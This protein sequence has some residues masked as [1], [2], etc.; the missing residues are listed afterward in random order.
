VFQPPRF[1]RNRSRTAAAPALTSVL[2]RM[3]F[4]LLR[5]RRYER[6]L[7]L[8]SFPWPED[9]VPLGLRMF[10][11]AA[12][13][14]RGKMVVALTETDREGAVAFAERASGWLATDDRISVATFP[15]DAL[16][17]ESLIEALSAAP[18]GELRSELDDTAAITERRFRRADRNGDHVATLR[19]ASED[20]AGP[21]APVGLQAHSGNGAGPHGPST[22][23]DEWDPNDHEG[24]ER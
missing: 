2:P 11:I 16:T 13:I 22:L 23:A 6:P 8:V 14:G 21:S 12:R 5:A 7:S 3:Q 24:V 10:D 17:L 20:P 18:I 19:L 1:L 15:Q 9:R 4:E